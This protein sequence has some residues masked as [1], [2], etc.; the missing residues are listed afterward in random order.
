MKASRVV[1]QLLDLVECEGDCDV[2]LASGYHIEE[3][4][5]D[6][7]W[8]PSEMEYDHKPRPAFVLDAGIDED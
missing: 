3:I 7:A 8:E 6:D 1:E 4:V 5:F 2:V